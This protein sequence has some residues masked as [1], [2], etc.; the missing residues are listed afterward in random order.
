MSNASSQAD[1]QYSPL[2]FLASL[3]AGGLSVTFFMFLMFWVPHKGRPVPVFEDIMAAFSSGDWPLQT[4]IIIAAVGI[5]GF[6]VLNLK[7]LIWNLRAFAR[8]KASP[9]FEGFSKSNAESTQSALPLAL[10]MTVNALF[11]V[12]LVFVPGLWSIVEYLFPLAMIAFGL[13][14]VLALRII[15]RFLGRILGSGSFDQSANGSYAQVLPA[16]SLA[17]IAVGM[18]APAAMS[19]V[20][21]TVAT[22]LIL[23]MILG[24]AAA[25]YAILALIA[26]TIA[27]LKHGTAREA[28][29][30]LMI[31]VPLMTVLGIMMLRQNHGLHVLFNVHGAPAETMMLITKLLAVQL[32]FLGLGMA[33]L[34][35]Q[36]YFGDFVMGS[37]TSPG[38]YALVC[39]FVALAVMGHFFINKGLVASGVVE[40]FGTGYWALTAIA[41]SVQLIAILLVVRLNRQHFGASR[42]A[43]VPAE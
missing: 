35:A 34:R 16:F 1:R 2:Y 32:V 29:P 33:V 3:G 23:S 43:A 7:S 11:I 27:M 38:S 26:G 24:I 41:L 14:A 20:Q 9:T 36:G 39:P 40:K 13:I 17:M 37:K 28:A 12:G 19:H 21:T 5:A 31:F 25:I 18:S 6:T 30:T 4:A 8:F 22:S 15:G 42:M 10:A